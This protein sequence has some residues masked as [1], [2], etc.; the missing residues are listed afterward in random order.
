VPPEPTLRELQ[1]AFQA[2]V[3]GEGA[4]APATLLT[5]RPV[6]YREAYFWRLHD[7]L[8]EQH[9][10][11][12]VAVGEDGFAALVRRYLDACPPVGHDIAEAGARLPAF[13]TLQACPDLAGLARFERLHHELFVAP[14]TKA[15]TMAELATLAPEALPSTRI[16][17]V[18]AAALL[19]EPYDVAAFHAEPTR[20]APCAPT[21]LLL[22][23]PQLAVLHRRL[24]AEEWRALQL[25]ARGA[26]IAELG[27]H[28]GEGASIDD[29]TARLGGYLTRWLDDELLQRA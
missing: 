20:P 18:P 16:R 4:G 5:G 19:E 13:L 21:R 1:R 12:R 9:A 14:D 10:A 7:V 3:V 22:W 27:E 28:L 15:L 17:T 6:V 24:D 11:L 8:A 29:A 2:Y 26:S 25:V 23:R